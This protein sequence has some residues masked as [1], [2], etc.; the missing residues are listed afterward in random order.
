MRKILFLTLL[1]C[2]CV[3]YS[4]AQV[5]VT[6]SAGT[7]GPT[8]YTTVSAAF[9]AINAGT[10]QG[11]IVIS[12][13]GNTTEPAAPTALLK[14]ASPSAY[15]SVLIRPSG[16]NFT[17]NSAATPT[18][19]RGI[20]EL[21]GA[22]NI[23][24]D[25]DD[26]GTAGTQNLTIQA[27]TSTNTGVACVR[28]SSNS[29]TGTDG[30]DNN[31]VK[32]CIIIGARSS[33]TST[34]SN[35]GINMS[36]YSTASMTTGAYSSLNTLIQNNNITRCYYG[37]Y[38][39]GTSTTYPNT[40]TQIL[41]NIMGSSTAANN[42][43]AFGIHITY[44][45]ASAGAGSAIIR[46]N[47]IRVGDVSA[48]GAGFS[49]TVVGINVSTANS[50][51][52]VERNIIHDVYQP[53][54]SGYGAYGINL[55]NT[56][57]DGIV[58]RNNFIRDIVASKYSALTPSTFE[59]YGIYV[60]S[61]LTNLKI[62]HNTVFLN[63][64]N[65]NGTTTNSTSAAMCF[66]SSGSISQL[67]NNIFVNN[68]VSTQAYGILCGATA[69]LAGATVNNNDYYA[70]S[71]SVGYYS[72][73]Q[74]T[75]AAWQ[76]ASGKDAGSYN[77]NPP[78]VSATDNHLV[79]GST[80]ALESGGLP[81]SITS[82]SYDYDN[83]ARPGPA[84]SVNGG[85][86]LPDVGADEF[87][88]IPSFTCTTPA[89]GNTIASA[90][91]ICLGTP[92]TLSV[93]NAVP[94][95]GLM[96]QWQ[97]STDGTTYTNISG[98]ILSTY[99]V[100]PTV[101]TYYRLVVTC[102]NGPVSV[103]STPVQ[104]T[105]ANTMVSTMPASNCGPGSVT[106]GASG[107]AGATINWFNQPIGGTL[108]GSGNSYTTPVIN[109]TTTY[110]VGAETFAPGVGTVAE[111]TTTSSSSGVSPFSQLYEA[112]HTQYL[113]TAAQLQATG[114]VS[115]NFS[116]LTFN[117]SAKNSTFPYT[118]YTVKIASTALTNLSG[119]QVSSGFT[120]VYGPTNYTSVAGANT[121]TFTTPFAW[122][123]SSNIVVDVCFAN[124]PAAAG[125]FWS[126]TDAVTGTTMA[127]TVTYGYYQD[128]ANICGT[129]GTNSTT[130][131]FLPQMGFTGVKSCGG[132]RI[133]VTAT[134]NAFPTLSNTVVQPTTCVSQD[135][136]IDLTVSGTPG[137]YTYAWTTSN[138]F[139]LNATAQDQAA[140]SVGT[141]NVT[142]TDNTTTCQ[143]TTSVSLIG[144]GGCSICPTI[145]S[146]SGSPLP[147]CQNDNITF[148]ASG[149]TSM[150]VT[151]GINFV[152]SP[153][154]LADPYA[155][156]NVVATVPNGSLTSGGTQ[157]SATIAANTAPG[158]Y[159]IYAIL[160]PTP[161]DPSCRPSVNITGTVTAPPSATIS[162]AGSP[163]CTTT[164]SG[165]PTLTGTGGG[166]YSS[167]A[168]LTINSTTGVITP[169]SSTPGT[170]TVTYTVAAAGG[171]G[172][173]STTTS[174]TITAAPSATISYAGTP[175]CS[176]GGTATVTQ[177]G[178]TGGT[179]TS[180]AGLSINAT[181]GAITL[182]TSTAGTYTVT[183]TIAAAGGC[184]I[185][186]T[187]ANVTITA[188]PSATISY[189][190]TP[191]CNN[192]AAA[193]PTLTG[194]AGGTYSSTTGLTINSSTGAITPTT[195][196]P[197]TY[198]VTYTVAAAAGCAAF[199]TTTSVTITA[200]PSAT[201]SYPGTPFCT[202]ASPAT[203]VRTGTAGG[204]YSSTAGLTVN[205]STGVITPATSTP[206]TYTVTYTVAAAGGCAAF[207]TTTSV[208]ITAQPNATISYAA[209]IC[210]SSTSV[211]PTIGG[212]VGTT[213]GTYSSTTGLSINATTGVI[214]P[215]ASTAGTYTVTYTVAASGGCSVY[216]A[217]T[218]VVINT[219][220]VAATGATSSS[221][222]VCGTG[223]RVDLS[224][225]GGTLGSG[226]SWKWYTGSCGGTL[227]GTGATLSGILVNSTTTFY[228]R[229]EGTCNTTACASVTV[230]LNEVPA[231]GLVISP[232][233]Y[234]SGFG[235]VTLSAI[236]TPTGSY[237]YA[238]YK[239]N[240]LVSG[241]TASTLTV[242]ANDAGNYKVVVSNGICSV[243][244]ISE[245][246]V[247]SSSNTLY[248]SPNPGNGQVKVRY[249]NNGNN[250]ARSLVVFDSKGDRVWVKGFTATGPYSDMNVNI[251]EHASGIYYIAILDASNKIIAATKYMK[252]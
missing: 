252:H 145:G 245:P 131:T 30:A 12:I 39:I 61:A 196:T 129:T 71:G 96:Y 163:F 213:T 157:A 78:F 16:G 3:S 175:Y 43:G 58:V 31:T 92:V 105:F 37:I 149:L 224:V 219:L 18:A 182:G 234:A 89:P 34:T 77:V 251:I 176:N 208:T 116:A 191:F 223:N 52:L 221:A 202:S 53:T 161:P 85:A 203:P 174:V 179:Y 243:S 124:D 185:Y 244:S 187:T 218:S 233:N 82:V 107:P 167:T 132:A 204:S 32:N 214:N 228:V 220:S 119:G 249:Y 54:S 121:L 151:Y 6:A 177:T 241:Q 201:I 20:I 104:I 199:S 188:M 197:G 162:Y 211:S 90:N 62:N 195:S 247:A 10:H 33:A 24:I 134:I 168:G 128:D 150:G 126:S 139:G 19:N 147:V 222:V 99:T 8:A 23:T 155:G 158:T 216:T 231:V 184:G 112:Q 242:N 111:G 143:S 140:V 115:G 7:T 38:A 21:S 246:V 75:L 86:I 180:T 64:V 123:G 169:T 240:V 59:N 210:Q 1:T 91:G 194:T 27:A 95:T 70:P 172:A 28:L 98:A 217:T 130:S 44:S 164:A 135:G 2:L 42:I 26:P 209:P 229:A 80:S 192:A 63:I 49:A 68:N 102:L 183:Y 225:V 230:T 133:P 248:V 120:T 74:A 170:Y 232:I 152:I 22:D 76:T 206:G 45:A 13:T 212:T 25:G 84:G 138:G 146:V 118:G 101:P 198:T 73:T 93:Q 100:T 207:S 41:D 181:T 106:L 79:A 235:S 55:L 72:A 46:G 215:S 56:P 109:T 153:T 142:V 83:D 156:G 144:P 136:S 166:T 108:L 236:A 200:V 173:F 205:S 171:C 29:T 237:T 97:S 15:T 88:G 239:D 57:N 94:G 189:A 190:G 51:A 117:I 11:A 154:A 17:I 127:S 60:Q 69:N 81:V 178:T 35:Y 227:I 122:N 87:D 67:L 103:T 5:S 238:W 114:L 137:P 160:S 40:G 226:A 110:Y 9:G 66:A 113:I 47:D 65:A 159:Y 48:T 148:T 193:S 50:G 125:T 14:S 165:S 4:I 250:T 186:S 141:Y 36:N